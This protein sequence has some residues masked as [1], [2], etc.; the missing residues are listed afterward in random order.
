ME[1]LEDYLHQEVSRTVK[2]YHV[3]VEEVRRLIEIYGTRYEALLERIRKDRTVLSP[4]VSGEPDILAQIDH[5]V[6]EEMA[7]RLSDFLRR[8]TGLALSRH[9]R[10]PG[11][12]KAA[13]ERMGMLLGWDAKRQQQEVQ[14]YLAESE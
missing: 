3:P 6:E 12:L 10:D 11:M 13:T 9:R 7:M 5:A 2:D 8:R 14:S 4:I 1:S